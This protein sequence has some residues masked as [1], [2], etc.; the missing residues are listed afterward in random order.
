MNYLDIEQSLNTRGVFF[1]LSEFVFTMLVVIGNEPYVAYAL[2]YEP[3]EYNKAKGS[4]EEAEYIPKATREANA[5]L[6]KQHV[7]QLRQEL[8]YRLKKKVQD[9]ALNLDDIELTSSDIKKVLA[10]FLRDRIDDP[11]SASIKELVDLLKMYQPYL[12]DDASASDFQRH[13]V[14]VYPHFTSMCVNCNREFDSVIGMNVVCPH[15]QTKY[16][17]VE[18][19]KRFYPAPIKL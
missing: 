11:S 17:W 16:T 3:S 14:Q 8:E 19:E 9:A 1:D 18:E 12:P 13:F 7:V 15:C 10:T 5:L 6:G 4:E 2:A